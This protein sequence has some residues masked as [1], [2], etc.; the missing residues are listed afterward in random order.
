[1]PNGRIALI[2]A[3]DGT[4]RES[5]RTQLQSWGVSVHEAAT[6]LE[7]LVLLK[8]AEARK[9]DYDILLV[10][11]G[12]EHNGETLVELLLS[13]PTTHA[14]ALGIVT[15]LGNNVDYSSHKQ[16]IHA[17]L[18]KPVREQQLFECFSR[19]S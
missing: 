4:L 12:V 2:A 19:L 7:T 14:G 17:I 9:R 8:D 13:T 5:L 11:A 1:M 15:Q 18:T 16:S 3:S 6:S 10:D